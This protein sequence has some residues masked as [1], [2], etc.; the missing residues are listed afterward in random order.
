MEGHHFWR[1]LAYRDHTITQDRR[2]RNEAAFSF[3]RKYNR[4]AEGIGLRQRNIR[5]GGWHVND[6]GG[7]HGR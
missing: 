4:H 7:T 2:T 1:H 5:E 6:F 3:G